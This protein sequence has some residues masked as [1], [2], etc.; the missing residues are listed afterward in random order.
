MKVTHPEEVTNKQNTFLEEP[1]V[2]FDHLQCYQWLL[3][4][5]ATRSGWAC[6]DL[7]SETSQNDF[8]IVGGRH[9]P[10]SPAM[11]NCLTQKV[12]NAIRHYGGTGT[13]LS[14]SVGGAC[15]KDTPSA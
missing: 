3:F 12:T 4:V 11:P 1:C 6:D 15:R 13:G 14:R 10:P 2:V 7:H 5:R 9:L 8:V